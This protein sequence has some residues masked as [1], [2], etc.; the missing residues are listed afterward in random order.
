MVV[1][2]VVQQVVIEVVM[3]IEVLSACGDGEVGSD[4]CTSLS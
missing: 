2:Q 4:Q 1:Q 3:N